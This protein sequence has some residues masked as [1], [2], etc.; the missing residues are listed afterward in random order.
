MSEQINAVKETE[1]HGMAIVM[2][3]AVPKGK[4][5]HPTIL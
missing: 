2:T 4:E 3:I 1:V 5:K